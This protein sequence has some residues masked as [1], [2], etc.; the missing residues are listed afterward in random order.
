VNLL[1]E[2][3]FLLGAMWVP[4]L[5]VAALLVAGL[6]LLAKNLFGREKRAC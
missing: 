4:I 6:L 2:I 3:D 5:L 1:R